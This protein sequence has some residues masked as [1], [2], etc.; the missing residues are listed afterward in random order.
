MARNSRSML[1]VP[2][3]VGLLAFPAAPGHAEAADTPKPT[4]AYV[5]D[6][7]GKALGAL[8]GQSRVLINFA[9]GDAVVGIGIY[10]YRPRP[11]QGTYPP[12]LYFESGNCTGQAYV[13]LVQAPGAGFFVPGEAPARGYIGGGT[14]YYATRTTAIK[15][16]KSSLRLP[17]TKVGISP[18]S[19][20]VP[21]PV[22]VKCEPV[23]LSGE[24]VVPLN[25][26]TI[27]RFKSPLSIAI[28]PN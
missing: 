27:Q 8:I 9:D 25:S 21:P 6:A 7:D 24:R 4:R 10:G 5:V 3:F 11:P 19:A 16:L 12:N 20:P 15:D 22:D 14:L 26:A 2:L 13:D 1:A 18:M 28:R 17:P 23:A